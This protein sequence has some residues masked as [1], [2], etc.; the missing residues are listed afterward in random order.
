MLAIIAV[1]AM[2]QDPEQFYSAIRENNLTQLKALLDQKGNANLADDREVTPLMYAAEIG[3]AGGHALVGRSGSGHQRAEC[4]RFHGA[5]VVGFGSSQGAPPA[6]SRRASERSRQERPDRA[7]HRGVHEPVRGGC[8]APAGQGR[9]GGGDGFAACNAFEC[10]DVWKRYRDSPA[11]AGRRRRYRNS[12]HLHRLD[13]ADERGRE[14][15][16]R[17][18]EAAVGQGRQGERRIQDGRLAEDSNGH[19]SNLADGLLC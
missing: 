11:A 5:D 14:P 15:E 18:G 1:A 17:G 10:G 6:G 8:T 3:S 2:A 9:E 7:D 16:R 4:V 12:R 13:A 19:G